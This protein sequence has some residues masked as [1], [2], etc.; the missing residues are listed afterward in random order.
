MCGRVGR[1]FAELNRCSD[2][3]APRL[4]RFLSAHPDFE[5]RLAAGIDYARLITDAFDA[6]IV[7]GPPRGEDPVRMPLG[8][9][10]VTLLRDP[11]G[12]PASASRP[13]CW[14]RFA[15][16]N[17]RDSTRAGKRSTATGRGRVVRMC[18]AN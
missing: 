7:S 11:L 14:R 2:L 1:A 12:R 4:A 5:V 13:S 6:D 16:L 18:R 9:E 15:R 3:G 8:P 10:T 17:G